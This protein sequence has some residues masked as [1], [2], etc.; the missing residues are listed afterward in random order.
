MSYRQLFNSK[1]ISVEDLVKTR[2]VVESVIIDMCA[3]EN[4]IQ[5]YSA[6]TIILLT[7]HLIVRLKI[8]IC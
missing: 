1:N 8:L 6:N 5:Q 2:G 3:D 4:N 7:K